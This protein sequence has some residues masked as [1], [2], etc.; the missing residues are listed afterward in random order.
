MTDQLVTKTIHV[1]SRVSFDLESQK[2]IYQGLERIIESVESRKNLFL[3]LTSKLDKFFAIH[4]ASYSVYAS[5][6]NFMRVPVVYQDG[7]VRT[8][9]VISIAGDKSLMRRALEHGGIYVEDFPKQIVG[10]IVERKLL[11]MDD[12]SSLTVVPLIHGGIEYGTLNFASA[13]P[14]AFSIFTSHLFD[15]LFEMVAEKFAALNGE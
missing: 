1:S 4:K 12:T 11:L 15:Y 5:E 14:F 6:K 3:T 7:E 9:L 8:G 2:S 13:A 10:N